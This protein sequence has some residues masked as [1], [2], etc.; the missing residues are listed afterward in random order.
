MTLLIVDTQKLILNEALFAFER[1]TQNV[2]TLI[3]TAREN[4]VEVIYIRHDDGPG[5]A[6]VR[7]TEGFA[8]AAAFQ[9]HPGEKIYDKTVNSSFHGT[10]LLEYMRAKNEKRIM[11]AGLQTDY[12][13][14]ATV[15][16]G[17]EHGFEMIVPAYCNTTVSNEFFSGEQSYRYYNEKMWDKRYASCVCLK[18]ALMQL[19]SAAAT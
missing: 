3:K 11:I 4:G 5:G 18:D 16:C 13:I 1:F 9:P 8:I 12:C 15:K 7:G 10:G 14:D 17:F 19:T 6:L 2:K